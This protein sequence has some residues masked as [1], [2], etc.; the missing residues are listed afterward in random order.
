MLSIQLSSIA[1][2]S[3]SEDGEQRLVV[4]FAQPQEEATNDQFLLDLAVSLSV[5]IAPGQLDAYYGV[6]F[7]EISLAEVNHTRLSS[8]GSLRI[9]GAINMK[10][11]NPQPVLAK[12]LEGLRS[13]PLAEIFVDGMR[14]PDIK[15][16]VIHWFVM[17]EEL[18]RCSEFD[19]LFERLF[20]SEQVRVVASSGSLS[21]VQADRFKSWANGRNLT[22]QGRVE[23]LRMILQEIGVTRLETIGGSIP[24]TTELLKSLVEQ[25]NKVAHR[26]SKIDATTVYTVLFALAQKVL[27]YLMNRDETV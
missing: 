4:S 12:I 19:P 23:K 3:P 9:A 15:A 6:S 22:L 13:S 11:T 25:R 18:E 27:A 1:V 8:L 10:S 14:T 7:V 20:S 26:G 5:S 24:V 16:K 17:V 2:S 21:A